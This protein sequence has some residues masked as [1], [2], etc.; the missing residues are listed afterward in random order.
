MTD[1][2][3]NAKVQCSDEACGKTSNVIINPVTHF[4]THIVV[5]DKKLPKNSTRLVPIDMVAS[6]TPDQITL[7]CTKADVAAM[8]PFIVDHFVQESGSGTAWSSGDAYSSQYVINDTGYDNV[9]AANMPKGG[10]EIYAGMKVEA[11][12][13]KIGKLDE[14]VLDPKTGEITHILL[15]EGH[16]FGKKDVAVALSDVDFTDG[17]TIYLNLDKATVKAL[18]AVKVKRK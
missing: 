1:I 2:P 16:L 9:Q 4:V 18:P 3:L 8:Q 11:S 5:T 13:G 12:D 6:T 15:R 14:L 7:S 17:D 10:L